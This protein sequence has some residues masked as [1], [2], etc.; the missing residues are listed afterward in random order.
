MLTHGS[1][2]QRA[3]SG[4]SLLWSKSPSTKSDMA[5]ATRRRSSPNA[6]RPDSLRLARKRLAGGESDNRLRGGGVAFCLNHWLTVPLVREATP[7]VRASQGEGVGKAAGHF[8]HFLI[9]RSVLLTDP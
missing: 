4:P 8:H 1:D 2:C 9:S 7:Y 5:S 3:K 6:T